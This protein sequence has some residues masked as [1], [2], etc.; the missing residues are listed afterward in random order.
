VER[1]AS[2]AD[3]HASSR[4]RGDTIVCAAGR[5]PYRLDNTKF[6]IVVSTKSG[7]RILGREPS[8][9]LMTATASEDEGCV[10]VCGDRRR[11]IEAAIRL[12][13]QLGLSA[14]ETRDRIGRDY[15]NICRIVR[16]RADEDDLGEHSQTVERFF[17]LFDH[18]GD[19]SCGPAD[20][21][22]DLYEAISSDGNGEDA[23]LSDGLWLSSD[24]PSP[25]S[26]IRQSPRISCAGSR[27]LGQLL[28][29]DAGRRVEPG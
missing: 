6:E 27:G 1:V 23:Y 20:D 26:V 10:R 11:L 7:L 17:D 13:Q 14:H 25:R 8:W 21:M 22:V 12:C 9:T 15:V 2:R 19:L 5:E 29:P 18:L 4:L 24:G 3:T 16:T 28:C